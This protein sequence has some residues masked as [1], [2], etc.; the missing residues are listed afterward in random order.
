MPPAAFSL[1]LI[2]RPQFAQS[3]LRIVVL[4]KVHFVVG[5]LPACNL[6]IKAYLT[7]SNT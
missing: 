6:N 2:L 3:N 5:F 4:S 7:L 1:N